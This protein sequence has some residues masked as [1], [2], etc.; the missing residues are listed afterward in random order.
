MYYYLI[1]TPMGTRYEK[2]K[3]VIRNREQVRE[4]FGGLVNWVS[5]VSPAVYYFN[6][7]IKRG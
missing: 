7:I 5:R 1:D 6:K 3:Q 2:S 4:L